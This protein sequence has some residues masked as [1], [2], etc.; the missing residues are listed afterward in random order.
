MNVSDQLQ[1]IGV[2]L[3][4]DGFVPSLK[5]MADLFVSEVVILRV[6]LLDSLHEFGQR[7]V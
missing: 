6:A 1:Q 5:Q 7:R 3:A 4:K 2:L